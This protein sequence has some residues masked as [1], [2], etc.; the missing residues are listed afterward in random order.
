MYMCYF[1]LYILLFQPY[2]DIYIYLFLGLVYCEN[3]A[4]TDHPLSR[5]GFHFYKFANTSSLEKCINSCCEKDLCEL[6]FLL[7]Q[8]C[9]GLACQRKPEICH[10]IADQL[11]STNH[12]RYDHV[13]Q[14]HRNPGM[15]K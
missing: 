2:V 9:F 8:R 15:W 5:N 7:D 13:K 6:A 3:C 10:K 14:K 11:I 12:R 1:T 4:K